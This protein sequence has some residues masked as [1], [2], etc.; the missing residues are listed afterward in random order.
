MMEEIRE[1]GKDKEKIGQ[2]REMNG[3]NI[4]ERRG[5]GRGR[6]KENGGRGKEKREEE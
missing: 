2:E 4:R 1:R 5:R 6:H 3:G